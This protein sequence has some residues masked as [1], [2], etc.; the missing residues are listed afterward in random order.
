[1]EFNQ[2]NKVKALIYAK[3]SM[4]NWNRLS[5]KI[6]LWF[7][8]LE[9]VRFLEIFWIKKIFQGQ[10]SLEDDHLLLKKHSGH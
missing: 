1:M 7:D 6:W 2:L 10:V 5:I 4:N 8:S 9:N 3:V